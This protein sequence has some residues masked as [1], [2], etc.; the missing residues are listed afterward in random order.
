MNFQP[1]PAAGNAPGSA[2]LRNCRVKAR[3]TQHG[4]LLRSGPLPVRRPRR[5]GL[6]SGLVWLGSAASAW[7]YPQPVTEPAVPFYTG[8]LLALMCEVAVVVW[9]TRRRGFHSFRLALV[10]FVLTG[11]TY[12]TALHGGVMSRLQQWVPVS[13]LGI[14]GLT[15]ILIVGVE[16]VVLAGLTR[17]TVLCRAEAKPLSLAA[18]LGVATL[19]N[20]TSFAAGWFFMRSFFWLHYVARG[21]APGRYWEF[22]LPGLF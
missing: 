2:N 10:Y 16:G 13:D 22:L 8:V 1:P 12:V 3:I 14:L 5:A 18:A 11:G 7:A 15:E 19:A 9:L 4:A 21:M 17:W 6:A 20:A